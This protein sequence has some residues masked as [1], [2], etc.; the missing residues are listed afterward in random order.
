MF[1]YAGMR[2]LWSWSSA[3]APRSQLRTSTAATPSTTRR[4]CAG[5]RA[6]P[7]RPAPTPP[8]APRAPRPRRAW[9][10]AGRGWPSSGRSWPLARPSL[11]G[12]TTAG[13]RCSGQLAQVSF[14]DCSLEDPLKLFYYKE[15][16]RFGGLLF[17]ICSILELVYYL[18]ER[19]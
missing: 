14:T 13:S 12:T 9:R 4:S 2:R 6:P 18:L 11:S 15:I 7:P 5:R 19:F 3:P 10:T 1:Q 8:R 17:P 16:A